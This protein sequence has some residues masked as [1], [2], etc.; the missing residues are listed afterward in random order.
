VAAITI[1]NVAAGLVNMNYESMVTITKSKFQ[2][3]GGRQAG[4][5]NLSGN[6]GMTMESTKISNIIG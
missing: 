1:K 5:I 6:S 2:N 3:L 4:L